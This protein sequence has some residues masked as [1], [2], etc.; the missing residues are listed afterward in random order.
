MLKL[1]EL[2]ERTK[3]NIYCQGT[4]CW[5][6]VLAALQ[7]VKLG[8]TGWKSSETAEVFRRKVVFRTNLE[9]VFERTVADLDTQPTT[10]QRRLKCALKN[11]KLL[12]DGRCCLNDTDN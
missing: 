11:A 8:L 5:R 1:R 3:T 10:T 12:P 6:R 9:Q 2:I 7:T 4:V